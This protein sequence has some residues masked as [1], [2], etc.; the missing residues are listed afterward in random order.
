MATSSPNLAARVGEG[1]TIECCKICCDYACTCGVFL[2]IENHGY[3]TGTAED[4]MKIVD[5]T[6]HEWLGVNLDTG[7]FTSAPYANMEALVP[8]AINVQVKVELRT[9]DGKGRE[10]ADFGR[11]I[12]ILHNANYRG[13]VA[14]EYEAKDDPMTAVPKYLQQLREAIGN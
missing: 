9:E 3:L 10:P 2:A 5:G 12:R 1:K 11:I 13:Y 7:N 8:H 4:V 14:L 6:N